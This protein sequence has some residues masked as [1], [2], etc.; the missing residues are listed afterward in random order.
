MQFFFFAWFFSSHFPARQAS[1]PCFTMALQCAIVI[2][3]IRST[4]A[5]IS[6]ILDTIY[7]IYCTPVGLI[8]IQ[9]SHFF[10]KYFLKKW[11]YA[12]VFSFEFLFYLFSCLPSIMATLYNG[13]TMCNCYPQNQVNFGCYKWHIGS[14]RHERVI[15]TMSYLSP[16]GLWGL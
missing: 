12:I 14:Y 2:L 9:S 1:W 7:Q 10:F 6:D 3:K 4:L 13:V 15:I 11:F 8:P 5:A 16:T